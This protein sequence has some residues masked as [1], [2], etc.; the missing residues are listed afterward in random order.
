MLLD[1]PN[2]T[3]CPLMDGPVM[4]V[5]YAFGELLA[6][7]PDGSITA[8]PFDV[9]RRRLTGSATPLAT[10]MMTT[11][12]GIAQF[13]VTDNGTLAYMPE[14]PRSLVLIGRNGHVETAIAERLNVH[15][16]RFSPD[17]TR[18]A[19]DISARSRPE[20]SLCTA[21][22]PEA[23]NRLNRCSCRRS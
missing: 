5:R 18:L 7:L 3:V 14:T 2:V 21:L 13:A 15:A 17:G 22:G 23:P 9:K 19:V 11:G 8:T 16:P 6:V 10:G 20:R 1:L 4:E 12:T